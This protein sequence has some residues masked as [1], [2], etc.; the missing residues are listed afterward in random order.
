[1]FGG[2]RIDLPKKPD[3]RGFGSS[4][5]GGLLAAVLRERAKGDT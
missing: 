1:M 2:L 4:Y 5:P 3:A